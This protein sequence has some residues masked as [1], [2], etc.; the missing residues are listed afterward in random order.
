[1]I[2]TVRSRAPFSLNLSALICVPTSKTTSRLENV[3]MYWHVFPVKHLLISS[4]IY[5]TSLQT[6]YKCIL[7]SLCV[8]GLRLGHCSGIS[9]A[10]L[11]Q[12]S[13]IILNSNTLFCTLLLREFA[14]TCR[15]VLTTI[16]CSCT[17]SNEVNLLSGHIHSKCCNLDGF[18]GFHR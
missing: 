11:H 8:L 7:P 10:T 12:N 16:D 14:P 4:C 6:A 18:D 3:F 1:M 15:A 5:S 2:I 9:V 13:N 17:N